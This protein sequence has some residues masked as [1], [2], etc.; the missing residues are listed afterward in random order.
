ML[1]FQSIARPRYALIAQLNPA[2]LYS[3]VDSRAHGKPR[4]GLIQFARDGLLEIQSTGFVPA[5]GIREG[6]GHQVLDGDR[7][8][9]RLQHSRQGQ[10]A[11]GHGLSEE[12]SRPV[13]Q[14]QQALF[15]GFRNRLLDLGCAAARDLD[16]FVIPFLR[17]RY[18]AS[19]LKVFDYVQNADGIHSPEAWQFLIRE[20][21]GREFAKR[22]RFRQEYLQAG[23]LERGF[24]DRPAPKGSM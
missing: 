20:E 2:G 22:G 21:I 9:R 23:I 11:I 17:Y 16:D 6:L 13:R 14:P 24:V 4:Q 7:I 1:G 3:A 15:H 5:P 10:N 18:F 19:T 12:R 8:G